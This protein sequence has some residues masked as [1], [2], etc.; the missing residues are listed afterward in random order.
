MLLVTLGNLLRMNGNWSQRLVLDGWLGPKHHDI[1]QIKVIM[2]LIYS[3]IIESKI[4]NQIK[5][6]ADWGFLNTH[7]LNGKLI[8]MLYLVAPL[9]WM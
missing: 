5:R 9:C 3:E 8:A 1:F 7:N 2:K 4:I 6:Y